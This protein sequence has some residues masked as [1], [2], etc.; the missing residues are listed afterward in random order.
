MVTTESIFCSNS[1]D[2]QNSKFVHWLP[3]PGFSLNSVKEIQLIH[4]NFTDH[5]P[6][7]S[8]LPYLILKFRKYRNC[9]YLSQFCPLLYH[10]VYHFC[11][12]R[13]LII[14]QTIYFSSTTYQKRQMKW[15]YQCYLISKCICFLLFP[16]MSAAILHVI[17]SKYSSLKSI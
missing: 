12:Y 4:W 15:C 2:I 6:D 10:F 8:R 11:Y 17:T 16:K 3:D 1:E 7:Y 13:C 5:F 9:L 14:H